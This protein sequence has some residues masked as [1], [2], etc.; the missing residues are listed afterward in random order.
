MQNKPYDSSRYL[1]NNSNNNNFGNTIP[2]S[3]NFI[4]TQ[5]HPLNIN[6]NSFHSIGTIPNDL[7]MNRFQQ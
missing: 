7:R 5:P 3:N 1:D 6:Q 2:T 4:N